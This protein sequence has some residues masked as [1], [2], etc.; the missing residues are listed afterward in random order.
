MKQH[1]FRS[2][3]EKLTLR[4]VDVAGKRV[5]VRAD[6]NVTL[7]KVTGELLDDFRIKQNI[8]TIT[9]LRTHRAK[10]ILCSHLGRPDHNGPNEKLRMVVVAQRL[11]EML[12]ISVPVAPDCV[13]PEVEA[14]VA[15]LK[16]GEVLL[17]ENLRFHPEEEANL[18]DF[19]RRL[20]RLAD[21]YVNDAFGTSHRNHASVVGVPGLMPVAVAGLL[22]EKEINYLKQLVSNPGRPYGAIFGGGKISDKIR[23]LRH[24]L[25]I[26]DVLVVGGGIANTLLKAQGR[27][28]GKSLVDTDFVEHASL[29]LK[30]AQN[31]KV[32]LHL[33][34]DLVVVKSPDDVASARVVDV[35]AVQDEDC[36]LDIGP[37]SV[38]VFAG[39]LKQCRTIIWNGPM[40][41]F[42]IEKFAEGSR[43]LAEQIGQIKALRVAGGGDTS[44]L[45]RD[46]QLA[47]YFNYVSTGGAAFL[48][49]LEGRELPGIAELTDAYQPKERQVRPD[50]E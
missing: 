5:L 1:A 4:D 8:E 25:H 6:F 43:K 22:V 31:Y 38:A 46:L 2:A 42:E 28:V 40:G 12:G 14:A 50:N 36:I 34:C 27:N 15:R 39:A 9:Y 11:E 10:V 7:D 29:I 23:I 37:R 16:D 30:D 20:A 18:P 3:F 49:Y 21:V 45:H 48:H 17:L 47:K 19:A 44:A 24:F 26:A 35:D 32:S 33:P 13:G 41:K